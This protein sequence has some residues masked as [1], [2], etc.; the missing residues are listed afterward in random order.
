MADDIAITAGTGTNVATDDCTS[1]H[2]Q[3]V[4]LAYS[5]NGDRTHIPADAG[6]LL[7]NLGTNN[8]VTATNATAANLKAEVV[9]T[10]TFVTQVDGAA[11]TALQLI[12]DSVFADDAA[13]TV[14]TS[15]VTVAGGVAVAHGSAPQA[16]RWRRSTTGT[17]CSSRSAGTRTSS[18]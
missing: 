1:G 9:G 12:D 11:L 5:A 14:G 2:A 10:G 4:K 13:F 8:D 6:G 3:V 16:M 7:V 17:E 15:K 18:R